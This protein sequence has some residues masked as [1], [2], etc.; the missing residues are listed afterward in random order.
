MSAS[1]TPPTRAVLC[2]TKL[3]KTAGLAVGTVTPATLSSHA[4]TV[5]IVF[6]TIE[7]YTVIINTIREMPTFYTDPIHTIITLTSAPVA[8]GVEKTLFHA[9]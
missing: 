5:A 4:V 7:A 8:G 1:P 9:N 6:V 3:S 2:G